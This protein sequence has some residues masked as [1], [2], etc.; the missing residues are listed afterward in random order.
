MLKRKAQTEAK[1][2]EG[3]APAV[4]R[5]K[6]VKKP[7]TQVDDSGDES[8]SGLSMS[9]ESAEELGFD[10]SGDRFDSEQSA[11]ERPRRSLSSLPLNFVLSHYP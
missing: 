3:S 6:Q 7:T 1:S 5:A 4:K 11:D 9:E 10:S 2:A 8:Y